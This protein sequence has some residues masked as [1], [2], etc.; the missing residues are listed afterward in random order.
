MPNDCLE[1]SQAETRNED[2]QPLHMDLIITNEQALNE[3]ERERRDGDCFTIFEPSRRIIVSLNGRAD[4]SFRE[5]AR[6]YV[7]ALRSKNAC[8]GREHGRSENENKEIYIKK[9]R[10]Q[11]SLNI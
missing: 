11:T 9:I 1:W 6:S 4:I 10:F 2:T 3:L 8:R 7:R 5:I